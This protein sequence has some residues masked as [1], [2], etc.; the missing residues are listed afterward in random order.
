MKFLL[1]IAGSVDHQEPRPIAAMEGR[2]VKRLVERLLSFVDGILC[3]WDRIS[4]T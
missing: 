2:V 3:S 4:Q 1:S